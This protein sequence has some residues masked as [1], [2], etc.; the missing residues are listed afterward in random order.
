MACHGQLSADKGIALYFCDPHGPWQGGTNENTNGLIR[1]YLPK[2]TDISVYSQEQ[3]DA[4]ADQMNGRPRRTLGWATAIEIYAEWLARLESGP[5]SIQ[6]TMQVL[7]LNSR[8][9]YLLW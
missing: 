4:I 8:A 5:Q 2:G 3:L 7:H 6:L 1:Q 9:S